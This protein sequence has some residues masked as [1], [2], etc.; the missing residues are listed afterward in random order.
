MDAIAISGISAS[1]SG[2]ALIASCISLWRTHFS[3]PR[4]IITVGGLNHRI[5]PI[6][7]KDKLWYLS[8]YIIPISFTNA[9]S[10]PILMNCVRLKLKFPKIPIPDNYEILYAKWT[11]DDSALRK[12]DK[13]RF[14]WIDRCSPKDFFP[15]TILPKSTEIRNFIFETRWD[16]PVIQETIK[17]SLEIPLNKKGKWL[18]VN[19]WVLKQNARVWTELAKVGGSVTYPCFP[20][21]SLDELIN[22]KD[23]HKYTGTRE[24]IPEK[25]FDSSPSYLAFEKVKE[26]E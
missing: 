23:L 12:I 5:Y 21:K 26:K 22:P 3:K 17:V 18:K 15:F 24:E 1:I 11:I 8:S 14:E 13:N 2:L 4:P 19:E 10:Q 7:N 20:F 16:H 6:S 9:G 25:G